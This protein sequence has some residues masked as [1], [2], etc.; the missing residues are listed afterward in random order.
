MT[1]IRLVPAL[2]KGTTLR[3]FIY[4]YFIISFS[5]RV[6]ITKER[7]FSHETSLCL[8]LPCP[9]ASHAHH[10]RTG[11]GRRQRPAP[12]ETSRPAAPATQAGEIT[13]LHSETGTVK[14]YPI[15]EYLFGVVAAEISYDA[16]AEAMKAQA[17]A[18]YSIA[19]RRMAERASGSSTALPP[20]REPISRTITMWIT[21]FPPGG[22]ER[23]MGRPI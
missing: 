17:V 21:A 4:R 20:L 9:A 11:C 13:V 23:K 18:A 12:G 8:H 7:I 22:F 1:C 19:C 16:P 10:S 15:S 14:T 3:S 5:L 2:L 6:S